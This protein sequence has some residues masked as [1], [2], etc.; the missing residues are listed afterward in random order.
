MVIL[1]VAFSG[2][3]KNSGMPCREDFSGPLRAEEEVFAS[4]WH[5]SA[6]EGS[7]AID[8][9]KDQTD[10][11]DSDL[12]M[13]LDDCLRKAHYIFTSD[14]AATYHASNQEGGSCQEK[15]LFDGTWKFEGGILSLSAGCF[16]MDTGVEFGPGNQSFSFS[17]DE[18]VRNYRDQP[19]LM[20]V[21]YTFTRDAAY[22]PVNTPSGRPLK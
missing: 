5:L 13:Q 22:H 7:I 4:V 6:L 15:L 10:N 16:N 3:E 19:V 12:F 18:E 11:P 1:L 8:L 2:C 20:N 17:V 21:T 14:R 9:T